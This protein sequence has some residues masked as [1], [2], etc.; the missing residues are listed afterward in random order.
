MCL[1]IGGV[2]VV[3][4]R[5]KQSKTLPFGKSVQQSWWG[6][7]FL[8]PRSSRCLEACC[9]L[10]NGI[11]PISL[12]VI[13]SLLTSSHILTNTHC[14]FMAR[15]WGAHGTTP[16]TFFT[17]FCLFLVCLSNMLTKAWKSNFKTGVQ[18]KPLNRLYG[19]KS[20]GQNQSYR[21]T[22]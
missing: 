21:N 3:Q 19:S 2:C 8:F 10:G 9:C 12:K 4:T 17:G 22:F 15:R 13:G 11:F 14:Y 18:W 1:W 6:C 7:L 16:Q 20:Q 5:Q